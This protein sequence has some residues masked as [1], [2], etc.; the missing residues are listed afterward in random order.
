MRPAALLSALLVLALASTGRCQP[1]VVTTI[2]GGAIGSGSLD[3]IG[4][5]ARFS[6][7]GAIVLDPT[8]TML[9]VFEQDSGMIRKVI[10]ADGTVTTFRDPSTLTPAI[11]YDDA[12]VVFAGVGVDALGNVYS[13]LDTNDD[14]QYDVAKFSPSDTTSYTCLTGSTCS[15]DFDAGMGA[16]LAYV[17]SSG[18]VLLVTGSGFLYSVTSAGIYTTLAT[19]LVTPSALAY[20]GSSFYMPTY[21]ANKIIQIMPSG[22]LNFV[23]GNQHSST[24]GRSDGVGSNAKFNSPTGIAIDAAGNMC[25]PGRSR[26]RAMFRPH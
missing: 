21:T 17:S 19:G 18:S 22:L 5:N 26:D 14:S 23:A 9:Y 8:E 1:T 7:P 13:L 2:A 12:K 24:A 16:S 3:G 25:V 20:D 6:N 11:T 15:G 10:L 4:S